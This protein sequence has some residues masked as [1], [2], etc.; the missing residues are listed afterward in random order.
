MF[1]C[2]GRPGEHLDLNFTSFKCSYTTVDLITVIRRQIEK[3][4][5]WNWRS[6]SSI[7]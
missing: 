2:F 1:K 4:N 5:Y 3:K 7:S 6:K